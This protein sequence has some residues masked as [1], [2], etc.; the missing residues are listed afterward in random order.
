MEYQALS[1]LQKTCGLQN[2]GGGGGTGNPDP[3]EKSQ[4]IG[5]LSNIGRDPL[6]ITLYQISI[7]CLAI[8]CPPAKSHL[9]CVLLAEQ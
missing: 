6:K 1:C 2:G 7:K 5:F 3:P 4:N 8:I 9:F